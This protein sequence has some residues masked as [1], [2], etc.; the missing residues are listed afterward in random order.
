MPKRVKIKPFTTAEKQV[1]NFIKENISNLASLSITDIAEQAFVSTATIS[2]TIRK[3]GFDSLS[4][5]RYYLER[6]IASADNH[7]IVNNILSKAH[8]EVA[9]T[10]E[11]INTDDVIRIAQH[12]LHASRVII[13]ARGL[14][15]LV[16]EEFAFQLLCFGINASILSDSQLMTRIDQFLHPTDLVL[17]ISASN[18]T[19]ELY[20]A[21]KQA[22]SVHCDVIT[23]CGK[24]GTN[25][26][27]ISDITLIGYS[28]EIETN[29]SFE[30]VSRIP[31]MLLTRVIVEYLCIVNETDSLPFENSDN[32]LQEC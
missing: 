31:L 7:P 16:A 3:C 15:K 27:E 2:R 1:L 28:S 5:F 17:I 10:I 22:K 18:S 25:L 23:L 12:I 29:K 19:P 6:K 26:Q 4:S 20:I 11:K 14:S 13:V 8:N 32:Q 9:Y 24:V 30:S 21:A